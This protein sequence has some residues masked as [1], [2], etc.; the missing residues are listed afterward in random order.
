MALAVPTKREEL[1]RIA[2]LAVVEAAERVAERAVEKSL[3]SGNSTVTSKL[4]KQSY[5]N[6]RKSDKTIQLNKASDTT[7][8]WPNRDYDDEDESDFELDETGDSSRRNSDSDFDDEFD[9]EPSE[10]TVTSSAR[11]RITKSVGNSFSKFK[12]PYQI[13]PSSRYKG[14][15]S[16]SF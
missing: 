15:G 3:E 14:L 10:P 1:E 4:V 16:F 12:F 2:E 7:T 13:F 8:E 6:T 11:P 9:E 5:E